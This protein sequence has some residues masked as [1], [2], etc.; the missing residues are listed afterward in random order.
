[1]LV[2]V[3]V[4]PGEHLQRILKKEKRK[5]TKT[6]TCQM[7]W[8]ETAAADSFQLPR[9]LFHTWIRVRDGWNTEG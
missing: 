8:M 5:K 6:P 4:V 2:D 7:I 9:L 3:Q 1:M